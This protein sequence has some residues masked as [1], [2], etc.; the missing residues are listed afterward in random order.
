METILLIMTLAP[1]PSSSR[2]PRRTC[3]TCTSPS[4]RWGIPCT[5]GSSRSRPR[6]RR[7]G[8]PQ[9]SSRP[10]RRRSRALR[11]RNGGCKKTSLIGKKAGSNASQ[12]ACS[13]NRDCKQ[14]RKQYLQEQHQQKQ[15]Q[16]YQLGRSNKHSSNSNNNTRRRRNMSRINN[17]K[18]KNTRRPTA[19]AAVAMTT[20]MPREAAVAMTMSREAATTTTSTLL[21]SQQSSPALNQCLPCSGATQLLYPH[22]SP[23]L[24]SWPV[25]QSPSPMSHGVTGV[26]Q[27]VFWPWQA[28]RGKGKIYNSD[29]V[30]N[31]Q[32]L[33][34]HHRHRETGFPLLVWINTL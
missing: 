25:S 3:L 32:R 33:F 1:S 18:N 30:S 29:Q 19:V 7:T 34:R 10:R 13:G 31:F 20:T 24:Q 9:S 27:P 26:Q 23:T 6:R 17:S 4:C 12:T 5:R 11:K 21:G 2:R 22:V 28:E 15:Q 16:Q 8:A 14:Q